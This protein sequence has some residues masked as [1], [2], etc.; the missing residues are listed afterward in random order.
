M[1]PYPT[2]TNVYSTPADSPLPGY[3]WDST[4]GR[5]RSKASGRFV[6]RKD[7]LAL[8][9]ALSLATEQSVGDLTNAVMEGRITVTV[10]QELM[11]SAVKRQILQQEALGAGGW[12]Q[13]TAVGYSRASLDLRGLYA[14]ITGTA[15]DILAGVITLAQAQARANEYA[16]HGRSHFYTA[17]RATVRPSA[18]N[19]VILERRMLAGG[20]KICAD[21]AGYYDQGWQPFGLLPPPT[22]GSVCQGNCR[23]LLI[24]ME[25]EA[26]TEA[27]FI[28]TKA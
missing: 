2:S 5:Y 7:I 16:G 10:W 25:V 18:P 13:V 17:E 3:S 26:G 11:A 14:K 1:M 27:Q 9:L 22:V 20:G 6:S 4:V 24:R 23:C 28:G 21:C 19:M 15:L 12:E 8:L